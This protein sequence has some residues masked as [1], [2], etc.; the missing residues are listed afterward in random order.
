MKDVQN[1]SENREKLNGATDFSDDTL[2]WHYL[3]LVRLSMFA[4]RILM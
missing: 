4:S 2:I 1:S 3:L